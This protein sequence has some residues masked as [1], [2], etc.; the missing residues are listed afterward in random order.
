MDA[1]ADHNRFPVDWLFRWRWGKGKKASKGK[2]KGAE[3]DGDVSD[4]V[5]PKSMPF[6]ALVS[7]TW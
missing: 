6:L 2:K 7:V 4:S 5:Q 3:I 1:N